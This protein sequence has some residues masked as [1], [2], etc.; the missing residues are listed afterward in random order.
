MVIKVK[1]ETETTNV[2]NAPKLASEKHGTLKE[3]ETYTIA[4]LTASALLIS[5]GWFYLRVPSVPAAEPT[6]QEVSTINGVWIT[7]M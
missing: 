7:T 6:N 2:K 3:L 5:I 1:Q 4:A